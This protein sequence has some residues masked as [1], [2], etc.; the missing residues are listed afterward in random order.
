[1]YVCT[2]VILYITDNVQ[3]GIAS[4]GRA[5]VWAGR[6]SA[7][8][9]ARDSVLSSLPPVDLYIAVLKHPCLQC[10]VWDVA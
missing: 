1:M 10:M 5:G 4:H 2:H 9:R 8:R 3:D 7:H 6:G